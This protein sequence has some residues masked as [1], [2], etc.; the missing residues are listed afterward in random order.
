M[1]R[2][3]REAFSSRTREIWDG[4]SDECVFC[5]CSPC[6]TSVRQ[7]WLQ[8][9]QDDH[10]RNSTIRKNLYRNFWS[11]LNTCG[12]W[13]HPLYVCK[14]VIAICWDHVDETVVH[15]LR[16]IMP[17]CVLKL[18]RGLYSNLPTHH[19]LDT[20]GVKS[21]WRLFFILSS[22]PV[23]VRMHLLHIRWAC[24]L[25]EYVCC[26]LYVSDVHKLRPFF[27]RWKLFSWFCM[28]YDC[29]AVYWV[30]CS[31]EAIVSYFCA[32]IWAL[33]CLLSED[34]WIRSGMTGRCVPLWYLK[35]TGVQR[36]CSLYTPVASLKMRCSRLCVCG[37]NSHFIHT[38]TTPNI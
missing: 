34:I 27:L 28:K 13:Q 22:V 8:H 16:E 17:E 6:V 5:F 35:R 33:L 29:L 30:Q 37:H 14:K 38:Y 3:W 26:Y 2:Y 25:D 24:S 32:N 18:V 9:G 1:C 12:A 7:Q 21:R 15:V 19:T 20:S 36:L 4:G 23:I 11:M 10:K 31:L